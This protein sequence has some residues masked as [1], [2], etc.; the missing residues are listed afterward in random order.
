MTTTKPRGRFGRTNLITIASIA[1]VAVAGAFSIG[2]NVGIL[3]A[4][5]NN[6]IGQ[7]SAASQ[8]TTPDTQVVDVYVDSPA[9][10][11]TAPAVIATTAGDPA[12]VQR[13]TVDTAG[14]I[15][16]VANGG[17]LR[18]DSVDPT[19]G[20]TWSLAQTQTTQLTVTLTNGTR[21][22]E[23]VADLGP[24]GGVTARVNEPAAP[25][26]ATTPTF[27]GGSGEDGQEYEG[28]EDD[29]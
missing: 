12:A 7:L 8:A 22:L 14:T 17:T 4:A 5:D 15:A 13:F 20:W 1:G 25:A 6:N 27:N 26:A 2:A 21:T 29:D 16:V 28:G 11:T 9:T 19:P 10:T 18:L 23:F 24:D 3:N